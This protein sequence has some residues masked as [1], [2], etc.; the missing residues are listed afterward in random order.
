MATMR[1]NAT[2]VK[3]FRELK[4][5]LRTNRQRLLVG[6]DIAQAAHEAQVRHAHTRIVVP[7]FTIANTTRGFTQL[8]ARLQQA[9]ATERMAAEL[10][11]GLLPAEFAAV[12]PQLI[13][14]PDRNRPE[15]KA[16]EAKQR[17]EEAM[18]N[19]AAAMD[20][21]KA[22]AELAEAVAQLQAIQKLRKVRG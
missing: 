9:L 12:L 19:R 20:Y 22:Q 3:R 15:T 21:A 10:Q 16:L 17:A 2:R 8:W 7:Q 13:Y 11:A 18:S 14:R 4:A 5:T 1:D 6:L